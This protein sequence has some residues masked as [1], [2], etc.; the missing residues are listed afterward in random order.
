MERSLAKLKIGYKE[1][2]TQEARLRHSA[3]M[4]TINSIKLFEHTVWS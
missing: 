3:K 4:K 1:K 2:L